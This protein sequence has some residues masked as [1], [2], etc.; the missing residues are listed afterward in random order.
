MKHRF[1][2]NQVKVTDDNHRLRLAKPNRGNYG[3]FEQRG[4][5]S[6]DMDDQTTVFKVSGPFPGDRGRVVPRVGDPGAGL[7]HVSPAEIQSVAGAHGLRTVSVYR[8]V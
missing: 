2:R 6:G 1:G 4:E 5:Q 7:P 3:Y 8:G